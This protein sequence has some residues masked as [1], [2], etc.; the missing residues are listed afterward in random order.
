MFS[1]LYKSWWLNKSTSVTPTGTAYGLF[2]ASIVFF[3]MA[4]IS[5]YQ[6]P[7]NLRDNLLYFVVIPAILLSIILAMIQPR[8]L[9]PLWL[10]WLEDNHKD[11]IETLWQEARTQGRWKWE[12][13][14]KTWEGLEAWVAEARQKRKLG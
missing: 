8:W 5:F 11:S 1:G 7:P 10:R 9:K 2:P 4:Y 13:R 6:P 12:K 14:V 3:V